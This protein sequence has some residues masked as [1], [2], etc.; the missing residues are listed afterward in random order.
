MDQ[1][2]TL[3][4]MICTDMAS[5][6]YKQHEAEGK[7]L[8]S[9]SGVTLEKRRYGDIP[10]DVLTV[11]DETASTALGKSIGTYVTVH[12]GNLHL[13]NR[14]THENAVGAV[15]DA[16]LHA[17]R[18]HLPDFCVPCGSTGDTSV[19]KDDLMLDLP[20]D[21]AEER[22]SSSPEWERGQ[23]LYAE[24]KDH[25]TE[26]TMPVSHLHCEAS[27]SPTMDIPPVP[28]R[29][30]PFAENVY[31]ILAV[32]LGNPDLT[33]DALG[34]AC[35][36]RLTVTHHLTEPCDGREAVVSGVHR[37]SAFVPS[38]VG[39]TG[40]ETLSLVRGAVAAAKPDLVILVDALAASEQS[41]LTKKV[42]VAT[43]GI[44]P[45]GGIGNKREAL[46]KETLGVPVITVGIPT[47]IG[48][49]TLVCRLLEESGVLAGMG[50]ERLAT[51]LQDVQTADAGC[52][53]P[54]DIDAGIREGAYLL[55]RVLNE[56]MLGKENALD[57]AMRG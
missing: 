5:E 1:N 50:E 18:C 10:W 54:K 2:T 35:V 9:L 20:G 22:R 42:Q 31:R 32:G 47:V 56:L 14:A 8:G 49:S 13:A 51:F 43:K 44:H 16:V 41:S 6:L 30:E 26:E 39:R 52:V 48:A 57:L 12:T 38:V 37:L 29:E 23:D 27:I 40:L 33:P 28:M 46:I 19:T 25:L 53:T 45:G 24:A 4:Q 11:S 17:L 34:P 36:S 55:A 7:P 21:I 3:R 15:K